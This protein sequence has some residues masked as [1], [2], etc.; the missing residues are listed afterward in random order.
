MTSYLNEE[1]VS[2]R[3]QR[4]ERVRRGDVVDEDAAI[5]APVEGDAERL[6]TLLAGRVPNLHRDQTIVD[7]NLLGEEIR[8]DRRLVLIRKL[9][10]HVLIHQ[11]RLPHARIAEDDDLEEDLFTIGRRRGSRHS[12]FLSFDRGSFF[13][14]TFIKSVKE[15]QGEQNRTKTLRKIFSNYVKFSRICL[16]RLFCHR[17]RRFEFDAISQDFKIA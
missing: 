11:R 16:F 12:F 17:W 15:T 7:Q 13:F 3:I 1:F 5:G 2:P 9:P 14:F 10:V 4:L 8:A 6:E